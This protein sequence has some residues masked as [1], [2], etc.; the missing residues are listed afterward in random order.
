MSGVQ[1][2]YPNLIAA[3]RV[4][5]V[6]EV[7]FTF[8]IRNM[9][10]IPQDMSTSSGIE[11]LGLLVGVD[12]I[13]FTERKYCGCAGCGH[14]RSPSTDSQMLEFKRAVEAWFST[15]AT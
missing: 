10:N 13:I 12:R 5:E 15:N 4:L 14:V 2:Q 7:E 11:T 9:I 1:R 6:R 8:G 3:I